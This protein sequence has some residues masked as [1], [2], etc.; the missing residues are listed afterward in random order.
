MEVKRKTNDELRQRFV[1]LTVPQ[2]MAVD[3][4]LPDP[5]LRYDEETKDWEFGA[6]DWAEFYQV[7]KGNGP[8]NQRAARGPPRG[9]REWPLGARCR[10]GACGQARAAATEAA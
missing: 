9:P 2:A 4:T 5:D 10:R 8:C 1:N 7:I 3:L 6:I